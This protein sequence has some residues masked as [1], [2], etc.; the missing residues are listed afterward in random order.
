M[1]YPWLQEAFRQLKHRS[2]PQV[3][4][5]SGPKGIG[6]GVFA[7]H[8]AQ[9][10]FCET[11]SQDGA[12]CDHCAA[13]QWFLA[14]THPDFRNLVPESATVEN[15]QASSAEGTRSGVGSSWITV[16]AV[17][18]LND[19]M[20]LSTHRD[21]YRIVLVDPA[22]ALNLNAANALLKI[23]EEPRPGTVF[24]LVSHQPTRIPATVLSRCQHLKL[25]LPALEVAQAW[26]E[27]Q[28]V[29]K[30]QH[31]LALAGHAPLEAHR[32]ARQDQGVR[33][34]WLNQLCS[35]TLSLIQISE[36][37]A[38]IPLTDW[39]DWLQRWV[40]D[41]IECKVLGKV[42]YHIDFYDKISMVSERYSLLDLLSW[43]KS[44]R[45]GRRLMQ[46]P[47]NARLLAEQLLLPLYSSH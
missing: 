22:D 31:Y 9:S 1:I 10:L 4:L 7:R 27:A 17:R 38:A 33:T 16:D 32:L 41:L 45:E 15:S 21:G 46:H 35:D 40:Y 26:L 42:R 2:P 47:L 37:T 29:S 44:L 8:V 5:I 18:E 30:A 39:L 28:S 6:C 13:C 3:L 43:E 24:M 12:G 14:G 11:P 25:A 36:Q 23:L 34:T 19:F 20:V